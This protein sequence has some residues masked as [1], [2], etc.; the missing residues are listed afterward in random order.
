MSDIKTYLTNIAE[1]ARK[2]GF[3][4]EAYVL[5]GLSRRDIRGD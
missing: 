4:P 2:L 5:R 3:D 1:A